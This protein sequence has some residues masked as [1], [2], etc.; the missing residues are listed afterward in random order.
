M[1]AWFADPIFFGRYPHSMRSSVGHRLPEFTEEERD[2][3]RG[4]V[5]F[6]GFNHYSSWYVADV[7]PDQVGPPRPGDWFTDQKTSVR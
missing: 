7:P 4:S 5:D 6:L 3:L 2:R 1:F